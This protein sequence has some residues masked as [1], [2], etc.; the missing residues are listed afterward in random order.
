[1]VKHGPQGYIFIHRIGAIRKRG[2]FG[3]F[4]GKTLVSAIGGDYD[5]A[6]G[7]GD[8]WRGPAGALFRLEDFL[9]ADPGIV[10]PIY[11]AA[12][13]M[14]EFIPVPYRDHCEL[15]HYLPEEIEIGA[16]SAAMMVDLVHIDMHS[17]GGESVPNGVFDVGM[18]PGACKI[19]PRQVVESL[20]LDVQDDA[21]GVF[22][23][24][25]SSLMDC[26]VRGAADCSLRLPGGARATYC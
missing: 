17:P 2:A 3:T 13:G 16:V 11:R 10:K 8:V 24:L 4:I 19:P 21:F 26:V 18:I 12:G 14:P 15:G 6:V 7:H 1:M 23:P 25:R 9:H 5:L 20:E 22:I